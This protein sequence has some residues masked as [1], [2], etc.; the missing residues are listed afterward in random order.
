MNL[1][2]QVQDQID[3]ADKLMAQS[4]ERD[5]GGDESSP[6]PVD[7]TDTEDTAAAAPVEGERRE[8]EDWKARYMVLKGK[9][10]AEVPRYAAQ[11]RTLS[12]RVDVLQEANT[13]LQAEV[14]AVRAAPATDDQAQHDPAV[15][16]LREEYGDAVVEAV[17]ALASRKAKDAV[18][19]IHERFEETE[20]QSRERAQRAQ[21]EARAAAFVDAVNDLVPDWE[22]IDKAPEFHA[23]LAEAD[24]SGNTRQHVLTEAA[25]RH[26]A[27][28]CARIFV[29]FQRTP[30]YK[31]TQPAADGRGLERQ[32]VPEATGRAP[33]AGGKGKVWSRAEIRQFYQDSAMGKYAADPEKAKAIEREIEDATRNGLV[34]R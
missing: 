27:A 11:V 32:R 9:Y 20:A 10:D 25:K 15:E 28:A 24:A 30:A 33:V 19:P 16:R 21:N 3:R 12:D 26:D 31:K 22:V 14:A 2:R 13:Q 6:E 17:E 8:R 29:Q 18:K 4:A 1:P 7:T 23:F 5:A 34:G